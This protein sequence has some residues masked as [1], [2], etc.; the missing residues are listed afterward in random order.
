MINQK[1]TFIPTVGAVD[2]TG[3]SATSNFTTDYIEFP[4]SAKDWSIDITTTG[5]VDASITVLV[6]NTYNGT[7]K[8]YKTGSTNLLI[9]TDKII[10]DEIMPF[11][12]MKLAY[13]A[14]TTTGLIS[15]SISK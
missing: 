7:Y 1:E 2:V 12:F 9:A 13:T 11:R 6:C 10:F 14:N 5:T 8:N 4:A 3:Y 15:V